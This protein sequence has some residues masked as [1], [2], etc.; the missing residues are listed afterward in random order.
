VLCKLTRAEKIAMHNGCYL[1]TCND[2][3]SSESFENEQISFFFA[4]NKNGV[5]SFFKLLFWPNVK[6]QKKLK[7]KDNFAGLTQCFASYH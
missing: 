1:L 3:C 5:I 6:L 7:N 2:N 4:S